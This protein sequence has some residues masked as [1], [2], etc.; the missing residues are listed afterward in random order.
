MIAVWNRA[1]IRAGAQAERKALVQLRRRDAGEQ[2]AVTVDYLR[3]LLEAAVALD[4]VDRLTFLRIVRPSSDSK[5]G[6]D[7]GAPGGGSKPETA[8]EGCCG[9]GTGVLR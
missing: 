1:P 2:V 9:P 5:P 6:A 8:S 4:D 3:A 7:Q